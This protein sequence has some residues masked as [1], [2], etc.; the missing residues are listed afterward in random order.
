MKNK[1]YEAELRKLQV[2]LCHLQRWVKDKGLRVI[3][4]LEGRDG[5][6]KGGTIKAMTERVSPRVFRVVALPAPS[7]RQKSQMYMQR[8][9]E[10]FPAAGEVV[11]FDRSWYNRAGVEKVM[12]FCT[13]EQYERFLKVCPE[14]EHFLV[15][16]GII[17]IKLWLEVSNEE[18]KRRFEAR[19]EDPLR[20][21]KLSPMDLPSRERWFQYSKARDRMLK[22]TD[23]KHAPWFVLRSDDKKRARLN[24]ISH[25]LAQ[26]PYKRQQAP[27]VRLPDRS[28][29]GTYDD[30]KSLKRFNFVKERVLTP[31]QE[32][33]TD[34]LT[35]SHQ[36]GDTLRLDITG[37]LRKADL[38]RVQDLLLREM[39]RIGT[40]TARLLV[41]LQGF[42]GWES[43]TAWN[44]LSFYF[45]HGDAL[46]RIAIVGDERWRS[47]A[48]MFA[49][50]DLRR[51]PV[52]F[53]VPSD[54]DK[55]QAWLA[56]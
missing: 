19:I 51:G 12:G 26:V 2:E 18:Q 27:K 7:D 41:V 24:A 1:A 42:E 40:P 35:L 8:Y 49:A 4:V 31:H 17:L 30:Q 54:I 32:P 11:I 44:D 29:K 25:I 48:L 3:V 34:A 9:I 38:D 22:A 20:Q 56:G 15:E 5:A 46:A 23:A 43:N 21:W 13:D 28:A 36:H 6:G 50:A 45:A 14:T 39:Q 16:G 10:H 53:F 52:E 33:D 47:E 37:L 55:A